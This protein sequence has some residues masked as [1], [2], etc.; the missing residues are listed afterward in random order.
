M[1][2]QTS[3]EYRQKRG[4]LAHTDGKGKDVA[5][6]DKVRIYVISSAPH[7]FA[8]GLIP[9]RYNSQNLTNPLPHGEVLRAV[10]VAM[11]R[12]VCEGTPPRKTRSCIKR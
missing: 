10:M 1:H 12:W 2:V 11:D 7:R 9:K 3:T 4:A 6:P 8:P 5:V